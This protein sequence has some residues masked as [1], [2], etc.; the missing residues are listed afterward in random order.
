MKIFSTKRTVRNVEVSVRRYGVL[1]IYTNH[2][3]GNLV[4][5]NI[6]YQISCG[7]RTTRYK[8]YLNQLNRLKIV[9]KLRRPKSQPIISDASQTEWRNHLIFHGK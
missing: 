1:T 8:V 7:G 9:E 3:V 6:N 5:K 2:P 4:H